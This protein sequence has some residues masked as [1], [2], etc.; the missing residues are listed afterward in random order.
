MDASKRITHILN[1]LSLGARPGDR[2]QV[3]QSGVGHYVQAQLNPANLPEPAA[4][5]ARIRELSTLKLSPL[6]LFEQYAMPENPSEE[7]RQAVNAG[8]NQIYQEAIQSRLLRAVESPRQLQEVMVDFW[9]N[10]FNVCE[11]QEFTRIWTGEYERS[12]IRPHVL[13]KFGDLLKATAR[14]PAMLSYLD[15]WENTAPGSPGATGPFQGL[16]ENYARELLELHTLGVGG[17]YS[18]ADVESLARILTGWSVVHP[19]QRAVD[20]S[21]YDQSGFLFVGDRH[22]TSDKV[23]LGERI[24]GGGSKSSSKGGIEEGEAALDLLARHPATAQH[25]SYKLAQ[26]FVADAPPANLVS[27]LAERFL[28]ADGDVKTV[29]SALFESDEFWDDAY[30]QR[31]FR[32]PYQYPIAMARATGL[33][34]PSKEN[35]TR[36]DG[37]IAQLGMPMYRCQTPNGYSQTEAS[38]LNPEAMVRRVSF[39]ISTVDIRPDEKPDPKVLLEVIGDRLSPE[40]RAIIDNA[41]EYSRA[42]LILGSPEMMYR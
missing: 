10:H 41:P 8:R 20:K 31:K 26:Y 12:A 14:H 2:A 17:G 9:F 13:G 30:Y 28:S 34:P 19:Q 29:L 42:A 25:I 4:L 23:L 24:A 21:R 1:R 36:L 3:Q 38:W 11:S 18:Q 33:T 40:T 39:A 32:T 15:N 6:E 5:S 35:L 16:N 37:L 7:K 22:D 27:R